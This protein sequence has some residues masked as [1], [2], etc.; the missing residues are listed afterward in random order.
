MNLADFIEGLVDI[1]VIKLG[2]LEF[3]RFWVILNVSV[4]FSRCRLSSV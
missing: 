2:I 3:G 4:F 1:D